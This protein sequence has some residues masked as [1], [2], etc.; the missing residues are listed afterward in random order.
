MAHFSYVL[1]AAL[2][3]AG[4]LCGSP[5][6]AATPEDD[7]LSELENE[8]VMSGTTVDETFHHFFELGVFAKFLGIPQSSASDALDDLF[9]QKSCQ[10][11][12]GSFE[13]VR[14]QPVFHS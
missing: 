2:A 10:N 12:L 13:E 4:A 1:V 9:G 6:T 8:L 7:R 5:V 3:L 11:E 14:N